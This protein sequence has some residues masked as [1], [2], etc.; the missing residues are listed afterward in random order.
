MILFENKTYE[1]LLEEVLSGAPDYIDVREGSVYYDAVSGSVFKISQLYTDLD[2]IL[3]LTSIETATGIYLDEQAANK[4]LS[5]FEAT[6][7]KYKFVFEGSK[8]E[9][10]DR[11]FYDGLYFTYK[12]GED[13]E[14][15]LESEE[16][17]DVSVNIRSGTSAISVNHIKGLQKAMFGEIIEYGTNIE[18]DEQLRKRI[19]LKE[20]V[21]NN[22]G[23]KTHYEFWCLEVVGVGAVKI[24]PLFYGPNT[25]KGVII[26]S[27][28]LP[29][30]SNLIKKV[31]NHVDPDFDGDGMGDGLGEGVSNL[32]AHFKVVSAKEKRI[33]ISVDIIVETGVD[34]EA[35]KNQVSNV[36][37]EH[38]KNEMLT[39][40][41][42]HTIIIRISAI[43][44]ILF[45]NKNILDYSNLK[46]NGKIDNIK[47]GEE[48]CVILDEVIFNVIS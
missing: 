28:G 48:E 19:F 45:D 43:A 5:R 34:L 39:K 22:N 12:E 33:T 15:F 46:M 26:S 3:R 23:T 47:L 6:K 9:K 40:F 7:T 20:K 31:Q 37:K 11:F 29:A 35:L 36:I 1:N 2:T 18:T 32:G 4:G 42:R 44:A 13:G 8:P 30:T 38:F 25:V 16:S 24:L 21:N 27:E 17:G 10:G 41:G 14:P